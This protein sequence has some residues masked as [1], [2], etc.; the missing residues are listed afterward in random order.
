MKSLSYEARQYSLELHKTA[1]GA[2]D[3]PPLDGVVKVR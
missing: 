2:K 3:L 1:L